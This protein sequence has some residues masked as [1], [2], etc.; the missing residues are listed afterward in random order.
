M[1]HFTL[2]Y[3]TLLLQER[4]EMGELAPGISIITTLPRSRHADY[5]LFFLL[6][7]GYRK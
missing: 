4:D 1:H 6:Y 5:Y 3:F 7:S 2:L